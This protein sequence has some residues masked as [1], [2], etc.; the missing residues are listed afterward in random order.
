MN[1]VVV[2]R[3]G[4][5][6][7]ACDI[8]G[9]MLLYDGAVLTL[10]SGPSAAIWQ[11]VDGVRTAAEIATGVCARFVG[12]DDQMRPD[13]FAFLDQLQQQGFIEPSTGPAGT[14]YRRPEH[15]GWLRDGET[16][17]LVDLRTGRRRALSP[18]GS[19][20]WEVICETGAVEPVLTALRLEYPDAPTSLADLVLSL[21]DELVHEG[22][23]IPH[24]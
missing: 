17:L 1:Q 20:V 7:E 3:R 15:V 21:L 24:P 4:A 9:E 6:I 23:L 10:L 16:C 13:V 14:R 19:R 5:G 11:E 22:L 8:E 2:P 12:D 18:T